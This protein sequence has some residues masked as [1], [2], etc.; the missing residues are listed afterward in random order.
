MIE[1]FSFAYLKEA[2]FASLLTLAHQS[3]AGEEKTSMEE[4]KG[5]EEGGGKKRGRERERGRGKERG[6]GNGVGLAIFYNSKLRF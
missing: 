3:F 1:G 5:G 6:R 2:L 4:E